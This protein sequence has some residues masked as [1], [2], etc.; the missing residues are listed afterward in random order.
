MQER[1]RNRKERRSKRQE[2]EW[3]VLKKLKGGKEG[4]FCRIGG[5]RER[6]GSGWFLEARV[7]HGKRKKGG[8]GG[9]ALKICKIH[10]LSPAVC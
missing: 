3:V 5:G 9:C 10:S 8:A 1:A 4:R 6:K 7:A 2:R